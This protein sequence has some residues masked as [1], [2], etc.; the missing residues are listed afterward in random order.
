MTLTEIIEKFGE[1]HHFFL[2]KYHTDPIFRKC[3]DAA[4]H[5]ENPYKLIYS[6]IT[7]INEQQEQIHELVRNSGTVIQ[8]SP[9]RVIELAK[10]DP[11][12]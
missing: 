7:I 3:V 1:N 8:L 6:L 12:I 5:G 11:L 9:D 10:K 4:L 2:T